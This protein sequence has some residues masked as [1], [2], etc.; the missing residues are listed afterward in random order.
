MAMIDIAHIAA[1]FKMCDAGVSAMISCIA[2]VDQSMTLNRRSSLRSASCRNLA[3]P[4]TNVVRYSQRSFN[5][6]D[7]RSGNSY[8]W[9]FAMHI[10]KFGYILQETKDCII[11]KSLLLLISAHV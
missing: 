8:R 3:Y 1:S 9:A 6:L 5:A 2:D 10:Y 7:H 4:A 11:Q